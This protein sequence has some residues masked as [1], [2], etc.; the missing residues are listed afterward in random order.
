LGFVEQAEQAPSYYEIL[1]AFALW[2]FDR[3][4]VDYAVVETGM[5]GLYD[6]SNVADRPDKVCVI[7]DIGY[8]HMHVLGNTLPEIAAQKIGIVHRGNVAIAF[9]QAPE[10]MQVFSDWTQQQAARLVVVSETYERAGYG[11]SLYEL[12]LYQQRNWLLAHRVY[13]YVRER[14]NLTELGAEALQQTQQVQVPARMEII[15]RGDKTIVMDGAHNEQKMTAFVGS[16]RE[17]FPDVKPAIIV[18]LKTGKEY[19]AVSPLLAGLAS[20]IIVTTF[21]TSQDLPAIS[22]DPEMLAT[23]LRQHGSQ[24][25]QVV[26][27]QRLAYDT[28]M[29]TAATTCIITGSFYLLSQLRSESIV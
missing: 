26:P 27:D 25:V 6:S 17:R 2:V 22:M 7:T 21:D 23:S 10:I 20:E 3:Q 8:D 9:D 1:Y 24:Q 11:D 12:P 19:E 29:T 5:G 28:L 4:G 13:E 18:A 15:M 16:F 14:D